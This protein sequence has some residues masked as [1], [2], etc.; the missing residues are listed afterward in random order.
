MK[1]VIAGGGKV[2]ATLVRQLLPERHDVTVIDLDGPVL[3]HLGNTLD[4]I[5]Y[6]GN[7]A[8]YQTQEEAGVAEADLLIAVTESDEVN[9]LACLIAHKLGAKNTVAR[10]R[11]PEYFEQ[12]YR[13]KN[14]LGLSMVINPE[15]AAAQEISRILRFP[16]A[17]KVELFAKGRAELVA[18]RVQKDSPLDGV[19]LRDL[20]QKTGIKV[21]ICAVERA[22]EVVIPSG[23]FVPQIDD[24]LYFTGAPA[25]MARTF[26]K[27]NLQ[28]SRAKSVMIVGG[29]RVTYYLASMLEKEGVSV[30]IV[31][32]DKARADELTELLSKSVVLVGDAADH[33]LLLEEGIGR[34]DAFVALTGLDEGNILSALYASRQNVR[35][36]ITKINN[37]NLVSLLNDSALESIVSPKR[38]TANQI[39]SYVRALQLAASGGT[40]SVESVYKLVGG[41]VEVLEFHAGGEGPYL[42]VRLMDLTLKKNILIA[43]LVRDGKVIIPNGHDTIQA[44][45][46]VLV[47]TADRQLFALSDILE[48]TGGWERPER[49]VQPPEPSDMPGL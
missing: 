30:K 45:D 21:L 14:E 29:G 48:S 33:E 1:I 46:G 26:K 19:R 41:R 7:A 23:D 8:S 38:V 43:C 32:R 34:V 11:N 20:N 40:G 18:C 16:S 28:I 10:V 39:I 25:E 15:L 27:I 44:H 17:T 12:L 6:E 13:L 49:V 42:N 31:E 3:S 22:G 47:V 5:C 4:V 9:M 2:G 24:I 35:R 36:V 37:D